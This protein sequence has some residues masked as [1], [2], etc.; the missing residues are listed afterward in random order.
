LLIVGA[1]LL[2]LIVGCVVLFGSIIGGAIGLTQPA[3]DAGDKFMAAVRDGDYNRAYDLS[4]PALQQEVGN[5]DGLRQALESHAP[6]TWTF[7]S[8]N[9]NNDVAGLTGTTTYKDGSQGTVDMELRQVDGN[10]KVSFVDLK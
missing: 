4:T 3:A 10:W 5:A 2:V 8:R 9:I 6:A 7:L 1:V